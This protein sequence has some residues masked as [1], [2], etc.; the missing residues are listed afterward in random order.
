[1]MGTQIPSDIT[2][3]HDHKAQVILTAVSFML[4][5]MISASVT[6]IVWLL[7][8]VQSAFN[9]SCWC[10]L[11]NWYYLRKKEIIYNKLHTL[12]KFII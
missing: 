9:K 11:V 2:V 7:H 12:M 8:Q 6:D 3:C 10:F 4:K 5:E 1:M